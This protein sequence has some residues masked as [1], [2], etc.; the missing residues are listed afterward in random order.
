[1]QSQVQTS[2]S[3]GNLDNILT[4]FD[5]WIPPRGCPGEHSVM[6]GCVFHYDCL[7][8]DALFRLDSICAPIWHSIWNGSKFTVL[9]SFF[10]IGLNQNEAV[11]RYLRHIT[12]KGRTW[13]HLGGISMGASARHLD[14][15]EAHLGGRRQVTLK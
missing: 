15:T 1:M 13:R 4:V 8:S 3:A 2:I 6:S 9:L 14:A 5:P 12:G 10:F 7:P 11:L